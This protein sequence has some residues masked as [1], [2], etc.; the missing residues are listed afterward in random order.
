MRRLQIFILVMVLLSVQLR[1]Q[2][3]ADHSIVDQYENIPDNWIDSVKTMLVNIA[4]MSHAMGYHHAVELL[5]D[6]DPRFEVLTFTSTPIPG[7]TNQHLRLGRPYMVGSENFYESPSAIEAWKDVH[8]N[9]GG[10]GNPYDVQAFGWSFQT[11]W[12]NPPGGLVDPVYNVRWAGSS[13]GGLDGNKPWGLDQGDSILTGNRVCMDTYLDA[14]EQYINYCNVNN[15][16]TTMLF[17]SGAVDGN[18]GTENGF[19]RE[20]KNQHIRDYVNGREG[21]YFF[22]YADILVHNNSGELYTENW[23]DGGNLRPHQQIHPDNLMDYDASFN[24]ISPQPDIEEDHIGEVGALRLGKALWWLLARMAGWDGNPAGGDNT[25]P[26]V[27]DGLQVD[28]SSTS[29]ISISWNAST[30]DNGIQGYNVYRNGTFLVEVAGLSYSDNT[31]APC[32]TYNYTV[33][34]IDPSGNESSQ[35]ANMEAS[36][37]LPDI[38]PTLL[39][40]PNISHGSTSFNIIIRITE[41]NS[42]N[43]SG[44]ITVRIPKDLRWTIPGGFD[45]NLTTLNGITLMNSDWSY[46]SDVSYHIFTSGS[47]IQASGYANLGFSIMFN[48]DVNRGVY[49]ITA[50]I[51][52]IS[53]GESRSSNNVDAERLDYFQE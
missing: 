29:Y 33:S 17:T 1:G 49:S 46:T 32:E 30:D 24:V 9:F 35:S 52:S 10:S 18:G 7:P 13:E 28:S 36:N 3:I 23:N 34:A 4:G 50:H 25:P 38:T 41:L 15:I 19:Q 40:S 6:L 47:S 43:T 21:L 20:L 16:P 45:E 31:V 27:P 44:T 53:G 37:C 26:S 2:V 11:T 51:S 8:I 39:V 22:D 12:Q 48:P 5:E 14:M 42:I